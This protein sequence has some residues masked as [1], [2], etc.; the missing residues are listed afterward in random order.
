MTFYSD[1][2]Y[3]FYYSAYEVEDLGTYVYTNGVLTLTDVNGKKLSAS[4]DPLLLHYVY[5]QSDG[6]TGDYTI[7]AGP[8]RSVAP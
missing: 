7:P 2:S 4:G 5:S 6:L 8:L 3:H 1:G